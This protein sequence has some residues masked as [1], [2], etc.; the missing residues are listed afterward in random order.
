M[1]RGDDGVEGRQ[2]SQVSKNNAAPTAQHYFWYNLLYQ[3]ETWS[4]S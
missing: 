2:P 4:F 3:I 1:Q